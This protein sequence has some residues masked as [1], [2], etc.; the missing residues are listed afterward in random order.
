MDGDEDGDGERD[1]KRVGTGETEVV[2][3]KVIK[4]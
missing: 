1:M 4:R 2:E 3:G